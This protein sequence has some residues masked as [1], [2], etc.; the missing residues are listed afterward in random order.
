MNLSSTLVQTNIF[1]YFVIVLLVMVIGIL[2]ANIVYYKKLVDDKVETAISL[3]QAKNM[4]YINMVLMFLALGILIYAIIRVVVGA[5]T[6][7]ILEDKLSQK[8]NKVGKW[9]FMTPDGI[10]AVTS[11]LN[12][13][14][15][16]AF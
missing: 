7:N 6:L 3:K 4:Y 15:Q 5:K 16:A 14:E 12:P 1:V 2:I 8:L 11:R 10:N 9:S 13:V